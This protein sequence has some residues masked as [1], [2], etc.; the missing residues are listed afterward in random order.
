MTFEGKEAVLPQKAGIIFSVGVESC[1]QKNRIVSYTAV[2]FSELA[3]LI[4]P[5][6]LQWQTYV[7]QITLASAE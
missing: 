3:A 6:P 4:F 7:K 1:P 5:P 2:K